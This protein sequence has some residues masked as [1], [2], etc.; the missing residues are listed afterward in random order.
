MKT[1]LFLLPIFICCF[2]T[3]V[4]ANISGVM[5]PNVDPT[6]RSF[7]FRAVLSFAEN[8]LQQDSWLYRAHY[9]HALN[10]TFRLRGVLQYR[11]QTSFEYDFIR[12]ELLYNFRKRTND[13]VWSSALRFDFRARRGSRTE[14]FAINWG[15]EWDF[16]NGYRVRV[17][18]IGGY[19]LNKNYHFDDTKVQTRFSFSRKLGSGQRVALQMLNQHGR[20]GELNPVDEKGIFLGPSI[21]GDLHG[22]KYE[23][24]YLCGMTDTVR[25]HNLFLR[26]TKIFE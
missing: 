4:S 24:R 14:E 16:L 22:V 5:G 7:Q 3:F 15:N 8:D 13:Q 6:D 18:I 12:A 10:D 26:I 9:Q 1:R 21:S 11:N 23:F 17:T 2:S 19:E 25:D 20:L